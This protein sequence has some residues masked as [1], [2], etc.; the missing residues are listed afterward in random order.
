MPQVQL[1]VLPAHCRDQER[2]VAQGLPPTLP[3]RRQ[4]SPKQQPHCAWAVP[5]DF[6]CF[7]PSKLPGWDAQ[8]RSRSVESLA[9]CVLHLMYVDSLRAKSA[10]R[11]AMP[12]L[13]ASLRMRSLPT[14]QTCALLAR[15]MWVFPKKAVPFVS[16]SNRIPSTGSPKKGTLSFGNL[17]IAS[18]ERTPRVN[19]GG[20]MCVDL[21]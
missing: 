2:D 21:L 7:L 11:P 5:Q 8:F 17:H 19:G 3:R 4:A 18:V 6:F 16:H 9:S 13:G 14:L 10:Q 20:Q 1:C 12:S 15:S